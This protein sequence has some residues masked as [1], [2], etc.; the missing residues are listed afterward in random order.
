MTTTQIYVEPN[1]VV[2]PQNR[3]VRATT[4]EGA[5]ITGRRLNED[6]LTVQLIDSSE[7]LLSL[8]K[9]DLREY[10]VEKT[11]RMPAY[12]DKLNSQQVADLV[13]YLVYL[14]GSD[15]P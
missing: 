8:N 5:V 10:T 3:F 13:S 9:A 6:T 4:R 11:S 2:L 7:R 15:A 12:K 14:K 1:A